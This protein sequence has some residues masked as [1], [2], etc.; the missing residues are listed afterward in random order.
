M[1]IKMIKANCCG[2][3]SSCDCLDEHDEYDEWNDDRLL[4]LM[5]MTLMLTII[6]IM[7]W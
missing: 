7:G 1:T 3:D 4:V 6:L 5:M 2:Y